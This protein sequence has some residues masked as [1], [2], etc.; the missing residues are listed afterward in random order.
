[1]A[2]AG[3]V[4]GPARLGPRL[5]L[6]E[7]AGHREALV[8]GDGGRLADRVRVLQPARRHGAGAGRGTTVSL[9][10]SPPSPPRPSIVRC[11]APPF[12][13]AVAGERRP[14]RG[15]AGTSGR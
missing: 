9:L 12:L 14:D 13:P 11:T 2:T 1:M 3:R 5:R 15:R 4:P 8:H 10:S 7:G 6:G